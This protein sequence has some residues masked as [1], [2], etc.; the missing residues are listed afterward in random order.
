MKHGLVPEK[1]M[2]ELGP[3]TPHGGAVN[4]APA[5]RE[6]AD[7]LAAVMVADYRKY[8]LASL[9]LDAVR[10]Y[11]VSITSWPAVDAHANVAPTRG[12]RSSKRTAKHA[13]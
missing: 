1:P 8:P 11:A 7:L 13:D 10:T 6:L 2:P 9:G 3:A 4:L 5:E 12:D